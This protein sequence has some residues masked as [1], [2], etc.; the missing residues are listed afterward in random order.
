MKKEI[1]LDKAAQD[2]FEA[3]GGIDR[4]ERTVERSQGDFAS[5][6]GNAETR[7]DEWRVL[8]IDFVFQFAG[9]LK[10]LRLKGTSV[11]PSEMNDLLPL[12]EQLAKMPDRGGQIL[13]RFRGMLAGPAIRDGRGSDYVVNCGHVTVDIPIVKSMVNRWGAAAFHLTG[14]LNTAF[15]RFSA[16]EIATCS[17]A[18]GTWTTQTNDQMRLCLEALGRYYVGISRTASLIG[19]SSA[20]S[21]AASG[22]V[23]DAHQRPDPNLT[24]LA[25]VNRLTVE[26][27]QALADKVSLMLRQADENSPLRRYAST[28]EALF[29]FKNL[30][31]RLAKPPIEINNVGWLIGGA[32]EETISREKAAVGRLVMEKFGDSPT[33]TALLIQSVYGADFPDLEA[34]ALDARLSRVTDF[35]DALGADKES[36]LVE[37]EVLGSVRERLDQ[38]PGGIFAN[39]S[40]GGSGEGAGARKTSEDALGI[41]EKLLGM[42]GFFRRRFGTQQKMHEMMHHPVGFDQQDYETIAEDY[43]ITPGDAEDLVDLLKGCFDEKGH[44]LRPAF[45]MNI[46]AFARYETKIFE[47]LWQYLKE[48]QRRE[49]RVAFLNSMQTLIDQMQQRKEAL[50]TVLRDFLSKPEDTFFADRNALILANL[51]IRRYN[52]ELRMDIEISPEEILRVSEGLDP[53]AVKEISLFLEEKQEPLFHKMRTIHRKTKE[54]LAG[55]PDASAFSVRYLLSLERECYIF[56]SLVGGSVCHRIVYAAVK[57]YGDPDAEI[58]HLAESS[59]VLKGLIQLLRVTVRALGRFGEPEDLSLLQQVKFADARFY[60]HAKDEGVAYMVEAVMKWI[61]ETIEN[62]APVG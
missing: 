58:Y 24:M 41:H 31:Q 4:S 3:L 46:S 8:L 23:L 7:L 40:V 44:F 9:Y 43:N 45:E 32:D 33:K 1:I 48:V 28:Y 5:A 20:V 56:F 52:K 21:S 25:G 35:I 42:A 62:E 13:I 49:D 39:L 34:D 15:E 38:V 53:D 57:E 2:L 54:S 11:Q 50:K 59:R 17:I 36:R 16:M 19:P 51:L 14:R 60:S 30:K 55:I 12:L 61:G 37:K 18:L 47:F 22:V 26:A 6:L 10:G 27:V 29:A